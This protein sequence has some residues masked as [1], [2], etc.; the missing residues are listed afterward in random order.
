MLITLLSKGFIILPDASAFDYPQLPCSHLALLS[1]RF[2][3][4]YD[5]MALKAELI[6]M[7][8]YRM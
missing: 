7:E 2:T 8:L 3:T 6:L 1:A 4:S 5:D